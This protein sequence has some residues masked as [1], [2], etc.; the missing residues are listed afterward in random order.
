MIEFADIFMVNTPVNFVKEV[1]T[2]LTKVVWPGREETIR[3]TIVVLA[4]SIVV[5]FFVG[6]FDALFT[7]IFGLVVKR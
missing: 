7:I 3:L 5:G 2:E 6:G 1:R 4:I